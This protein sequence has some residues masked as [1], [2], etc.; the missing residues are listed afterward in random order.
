MITGS[1][2]VTFT[3]DNGATLTPTTGTLGG[4]GYT[5][6][7]TVLDENTL[8][9]VHQEK[10]LT[11]TDG[12]CSWRLIATLGDP[13]FPPR[14]A[15]G[16]DGR[17]YAWSDN[18][19]WSLRHDARGPRML[20]QPVHFVGFAVD[21]ENPD[22]LRAGGHDGASTNGSIWDST[23]GGETWDFVGNVPRT[24]MIYRVVFDPNNLDHIVIGTLFEG[25]FV[26]FDG[27]RTWTQSTGIKGS[28]GTNVFE[29]VISPADPNVV[30][31][32]GIDMAE[33]DANIESHGRHIYLSNDGGLSFRPVI[34]EAP[35]VKLINGPT[36]AAHPKKADVLYFVFGTHVMGY[37]TDLFRYDASLDA[38]TVTHNEHHG[39]NSIAFSPKDSRVMYLGLEVVNG[40]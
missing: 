30:W 36:M 22:H 18:R 32:M 10:F 5:Y 28:R 31:A 13:E 29:L 11:S 33:S 9:A 40:H 3:R 20:K 34:D 12:G 17:V 39:I 19:Q 26:S 7:L 38:L 2:A 6:G 16:S 23:D 35:G 8:M 25:S 14:L 1:P 27:G 15:A 24:A 21:P 37:G 4:I